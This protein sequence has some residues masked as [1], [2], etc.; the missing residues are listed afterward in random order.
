MISAAMQRAITWRSGR[1][2][3]LTMSARMLLCELL[4]CVPKA[5]PADAFYVHGDTLSIRLGCSRA[6]LTRWLKDLREL[7]W[8]L[9]DQGMLDARRRGFQ[10]ATTRLT[11]EAIELLGLVP[12]SPALASR[13]ASMSNACEGISS[14]SSSKSNEADATAPAPG[15]LTSTPN[16]HRP[17]AEHE[18]RLPGHLKPMLEVMTAREVCGLM[19]LAK[20]KGIRLEHIWSVSETNIR[21]AKNRVAYMRTLLNQNIDWKHLGS[22]KVEAQEKMARAANKAS[23]RKAAGEALKAMSQELRGR[24]YTNA[25]R[26]KHYQV[27]SDWITVWWVDGREIREGTMPWSVDFGNAV[28]DG[29]LVEVQPDQSNVASWLKS[30]APLH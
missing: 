26:T 6:T 9:R 30:N 10:V 16:T 18:P 27:L 22:L 15:S 21:G 29:R 5:R 3:D 2:K 11:E 24:T 19:R 7:G 23:E 8:L 25:A 1:F 14:K 28:A 20:G 17:Q 13:C 4:R 12:P